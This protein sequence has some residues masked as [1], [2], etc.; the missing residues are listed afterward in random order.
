MG[1]IEIVQKVI[2]GS[3]KSDIKYDKELVRKLFHRIY[4]EDYSYVIQEIKSLIRNNASDGELIAAVTKASATEKER[5]L[6]QGKQHKKGIRVYEISS[7][8]NRS[9]QAEM[10]NNIDKSGSGKVDKL[11]SAVEALTKQV[12]SPK[13]EL[14]EIKNK[15]R[16]DKYYSESKYL[17]RGCFNNNK[18]YCNHFYKCGSSSH[19][20]RGCNTPPS[21]N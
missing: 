5:N 6:V 1:C 8:C 16:G 15:K 14:R 20:A 9:N 12:N 19:M 7:T 3:N 21:G 10:D 17:C 4:K 18:N 11:L 13:S 2:L